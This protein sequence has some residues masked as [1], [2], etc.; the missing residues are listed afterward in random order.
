MAT[1][2]REFGPG[3]AVYPTSN[4][5]APIMMQGTNFPVPGIAF[6]ATTQETCFFMFAAESYGSGNLTLRLQWYADTATAE[7]VVWGVSLAA[8]TPNSDT[9]DIETKAFA[10]EVTQQDTHLGTTGQRLHEVTLTLNQLDSIANGD[11]CCL[12]VRRVPGDANDD[13]AGDAIL[14]K[15]VLEYSDT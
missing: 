1:V 10:T 15:I 5:A 13:L 6:D 4:P 11:W 14:V 12:R 3:D 8:I 9:Q 2:R 7:D